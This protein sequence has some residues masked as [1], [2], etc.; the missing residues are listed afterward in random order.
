DLVAAVAG[1]AARPD[2]VL[3]AVTGQ[4]ADEPGPARAAHL[5]AHEALALA[6]DWLARPELEAARLVVVT[7]GAVRAANA[8]PADELTGAAVWGLLRAAQSEHPGRIVLA[9]LD[10]DLDAP[11]VALLAAAADDPAAAQL[12]VRADTTYTPRLVRADTPPAPA[13]RPLGGTVL[14]TGGTGA[15]GALLARHLVTD[16][17]VDSL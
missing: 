10:R 17:G 5:A 16:R 14:V 1:G 9:D 13:R 4:R 7:R 8:D 6:Q 2:A 12:A 11:A 15:L 3:A